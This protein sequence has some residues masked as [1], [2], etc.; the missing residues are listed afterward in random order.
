LDGDKAL[1]KQEHVNL[2][3]KTLEQVKDQNAATQWIENRLGFLPGGVWPEKWV[4]AKHHDG[5]FNALAA[6]LG[7]TVDSLSEFVEAAELA[8]KHDELYVLSQKLNLPVATIEG[9]FIKC[10]LEKSEAEVEEI[11]QFINGFLP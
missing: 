8:D 9:R 7:V 2:F 5:A 6:E 1:K 11:R 4:V 3:L 10:A